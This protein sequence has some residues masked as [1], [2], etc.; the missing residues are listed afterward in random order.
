[1]VKLSRQ[2]RCSASIFF[3]LNLLTSCPALIS[4]VNECPEHILHS[5]RRSHCAAYCPKL[6]ATNCKDACNSERQEMSYK[7]VISTLVEKLYYRKEIVKFARG[8][9]GQSMH[10]LMI[11]P[12]LRTS[13]THLRLT[14]IKSS[15]ISCKDSTAQKIMKHQC[16]A[17]EHGV[18]LGFSKLS[19]IKSQAAPDIAHTKHNNV[20][21]TPLRGHFSWSILKRAFIF[22]SLG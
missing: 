2:R 17:I 1:M 3:H 4:N 21:D 15:Q 8:I 7:H 14:W 22:V 18:I 16:I 19:E 20:Q 9:W 5:F 13:G 10:F 11:S 6:Q 12:I